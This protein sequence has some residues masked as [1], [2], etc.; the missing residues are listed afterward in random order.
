MSRRPASASIPT[1][2]RAACPACTAFRRSIFP[3]AACSPT[4][5][6]WALSRRRPAGGQLR[7][8]PRG[9]RSRA[10][11]RHRHRCDCARRT[12]SRNRRCPTRPR[13]PPPTTAATFPAIVR[14]GD[15]A[16]ASTTNFNKRKREAAR[17][18]KLRG[19]GISCM[20]EHA[21][22]LPT[23]GA[24]LSFPGGDKL[25]IGAQRAI[26]RAKPRHRVRPPAGGT[27]SASTAATI[28]HRH[29]DTRAEIVGFASV[30]SRSA[31]AAGN[32][33][34]QT[35]DVMLAK[36]KKVA[37]ALLEASEADIQYRKGNFEVVGTDRKRLAVRDGA[38]RQGN[39]REPRHQGKG[40]N[41]AHLP[42]R[43]AHRRGGDRSRQRQG[44]SSS[45][46]PRST[47]AATC[48]TR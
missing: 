40:R 32:A 24:L 46:T 31:M 29:G 27:S 39:E 21:G 17:R 35:A 43:R 8:R 44:R 6:R 18:K 34:V 3:R 42:E 26:D 15:G 38:P 4:R 10:H 22:A 13:S 48:S 16:V 41:A 45:P 28:E 11:H 25:V 37:A 20:L 9:G 2:S 14:Q 23:E 47:T 1:T 7:A 19:I 36:G 30:G 12:S 5:R 33:I